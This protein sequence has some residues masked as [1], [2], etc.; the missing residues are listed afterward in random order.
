[1]AKKDY[2]E[3]LGVSR[4]SSKEEIKKVYK[5]LA[6]K[7]HPDL[8]KDNK[9]AE[10]KFK[11][12]NEAAST[13]SD[14]AKRAQYDQFGSEGVNFGGQGGQGFGG[15]FS[16]SQGFDFNDIFDNFFGGGGQGGRSRYRG[17]KPG[18]DLRYDI[19][20]DLEDVANGLEKSI[21]V[22]KKDSC[23]TCD[24]QGGS[25]L[26]TCST[27]HGQGVVVS[28][29]QT[30]FGTFQS[31]S[32]CPTC[33]GRGKSI[34][35]PCNSCHGTG[36]EVREKTIKISIPA[37]VANGSRLRVTG[38][39]EAGEAGASKGDLYIFI[40]VREHAFFE[41]DD[42]DLYID[43]PISYAQAVNGDSIKVP[44]ITSK[45]E[46]K[47]PS[48]IQP[49]TLLRM[50]GKGLPI[51]RRSGSGNQ[52]VKIVVEVPKKISKKQKKSLDDFEK[53]FTGKKPHEKLFEKIH[54]LF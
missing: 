19:T 28:Q 34:K 7:Y 9:G 3:T 10:A 29:R 35:D 20:I 6:K 25:G 18:N 30:P 45:A 24:G 2:Y 8:N 14:D 40:H 44:T 27:C 38:E 11:E 41:R 22:K 42:Y 53:A 21:R 54:K 23:T 15:G 5:K 49:G 4:D 51:L 32:T 13:L 46:L 17:P 50:K 26:D 52:Y 39:G 43:V 47:I 37:G 1:M 48:G 16:G 36:F 33:R 31:Q 12:I